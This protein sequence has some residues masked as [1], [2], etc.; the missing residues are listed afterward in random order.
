M[1][2]CKAPAI[3]SG[4]I[5]VW[6]DS[7]KGQSRYGALIRAATMSEYTHVGIALKYPNG[8]Y[9]AEANIPKVRIRPVTIE[10]SIYYLETP[11][12]HDV[13]GDNFIFPKLGLPYSYVDAVRSVF[14]ITMAQE[15][16]WQCAE[17]V[18]EYMKAYGH[19]LGKVYTPSKLVR[20]A[21]EEFNTPL[22]RL[23]E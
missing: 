5:I 19:D 17:F 11:I 16:K 1:Q 4:D 7:F 14:G 9:V 10:G 23:K 15:D 2:N 20:A 3:K 6:S 12:D 8:L 13:T 22:R 21:M 18:V